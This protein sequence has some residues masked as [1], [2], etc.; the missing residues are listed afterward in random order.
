MDTILYNSYRFSAANSARVSIAGKNS[1]QYTT[2]GRFG[3]D[4]S[5]FVNYVLRNSGY[6]VGYL[7]TSA[8]FDAQKD[9]T[10]AAAEWQ[11]AIAAKDVRQGDLVYFNGH[12]GFVVS[13]D[14][15]TGSG[16][17]RSSTSSLG[18]ADQP[19]NINGGTYWDLADGFNDRDSTFAIRSRTSERHQPEPNWIHIGRLVSRHRSLGIQRSGLQRR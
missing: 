12:V 15:T 9:L 16:I 11:T 13:F 7:P 6:A 2:D 14:P 18:V 19:F 1:G 4:C 10:N 5:G 3:F 8:T 17:F